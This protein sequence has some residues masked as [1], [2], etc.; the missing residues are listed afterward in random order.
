MAIAAAVMCAIAGGAIT[1]AG[2]AATGAITIGGIVIGA[3]IAPRTAGIMPAATTTIVRMR[4]RITATPIAA[5]MHTASACAGGE[6]DGNVTRSRY[7]NAR[8]CPWRFFIP[9]SRK[10]SALCVELC[11]LCV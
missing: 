6:L 1:I 4:G 10:R 7:D 3:A 2:V 8:V 9:V 11:P 5:L